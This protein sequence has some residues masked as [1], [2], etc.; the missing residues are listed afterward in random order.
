M[1]IGYSDHAED[2]LRERGISKA[3]VKEALRLGAKMSAHDG[4]RTCTY[5]G[6]MVIYEIKGPAKIRVVT[7][8][9]A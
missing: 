4:L 1:M 7:I 9:R 8:Y 5:K 3:E 2:R 6:L